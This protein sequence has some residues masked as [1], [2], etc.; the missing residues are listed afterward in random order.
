[1]WLAAG[2]VATLVSVPAIALVL[3]ASRLFE[4]FLS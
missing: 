2:I 4:R 1:M 3:R